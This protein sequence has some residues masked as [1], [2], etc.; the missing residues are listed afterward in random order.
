MNHFGNNMSIQ[1]EQ[2]LEEQNFF[3]K[4]QF[5]QLSIAAAFS[6]ANVYKKTGDQAKS[7]ENHRNRFKQEL[8]E[9]VNDSLIPHIEKENGSS[10]SLLSAILDI[11]NF[12]KKAFNDFLEGGELKI[13]VCQKIINLYLKYLWCAQLIDF[14]PPHFPLDRMIQEKTIKKVLVN[15]TEMTEI[16]DT[17]LSYDTIINKLYT[18]ED[19]AEWE[20]KSYN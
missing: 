13:G 17:E 10:E 4:N 18:N 12:S 8:F 2:L 19:K 3:L 11:Q 5:W 6:R 9:Y 15:W 16:K 1:S 14:T 7:I 20:L